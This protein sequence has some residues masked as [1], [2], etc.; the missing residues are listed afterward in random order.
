MLLMPGLLLI[1]A[2][3]AYI[4]K[5]RLFAFCVRFSIFFFLL[6]VLHIILQLNNLEHLGFS[7]WQLN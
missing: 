3:M 6:F 1:S 5:K 2:V 7:S 4:L